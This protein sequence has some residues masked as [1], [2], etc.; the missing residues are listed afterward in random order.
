MHIDELLACSAFLTNEGHYKDI[1]SVA[2]FESFYAKEKPVAILKLQ[3]A[4]NWLSLKDAFRSE[5][6]LDHR[7]RATG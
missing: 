1:R 6:A 5:A 2:S 3:R 7:S 4:L